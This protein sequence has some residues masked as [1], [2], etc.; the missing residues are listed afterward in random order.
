MDLKL[1]DFYL[2]REF[3]NVAVI[4]YLTNRKI[5]F[6]IPCVKRE[7]SGGIREL[8]KGRKSYSAEYT[9]RFKED[10]ATFQVNVVVKYSKDKY[11]EKGVKLFAYCCIQHEFTNRKHI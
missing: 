9:M 6:I 2:D 5:P 7:R 1:K 3:F 4:N 8:L 11:K 10:E